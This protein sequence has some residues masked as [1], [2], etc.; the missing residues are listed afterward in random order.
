MNRYLLFGTALLFLISIGMNLYAQD[1]YPLTQ[2]SIR[3]EG[4]PEGEVK[5][6]FSFE[7]EIFP[8]T[9]RNYWIYVPQQYDSAKPACTM[10]VQDGIS[11]AND[12]KLQIA[13]DNLIHK[14]EIPITIGIFVA[15]GGVPSQKLDAFQRF[16]RSFEY[17]SLGDRYARFLIEELIPKV[18]E[19]Y[20][21]SDD[22]NDRLLAG[23]SSGGI[24]A[25]N[26]AWERPD[27]FRRVISTIGTF[28]GLRGGHEFPTLVR[29]MEPKPLRVYLQDGSSDLDI[30]AGSWWVANQDMLSSLQWAGYDVNH[31]W[32]KGGHN[33]RHGAAIM[34]DALRWIWRDYPAPVR[35]VEGK[36]RRTDILIPNEKWKLVHNAIGTIT[37]IISN[38][39][40]DVIYSVQNK[41]YVLNSNHQAKLYIEIDSE[42]NQIA[43]GKDGSL[44]ASIPS[45]KQIV[46]LTQDGKAKRVASDVVCDDFIVTEKGIYFV[47][48]SAGQC[49]FINTESKQTTISDLVTKPS[50]LSLNSE[51]AFLNVGDAASNFG[52]TYLIEL[53][54]TLAHGQQYMHYHVPYGKTTTEVSGM[55]TDT[56]NRLYSATNM[57]VQVMDQLGRVHIILENPKKYEELS[58]LT[59]GG[60]GFHSLFVT[61]GNKIYQRTIKATGTFAWDDPVKPPRPRL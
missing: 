58:G 39:Y 29:K 38:P 53:D 2:D 57:G 34:P 3:Q 41:I 37:Y 47:N 1:E 24:C 26:A 52:F 13:L 49:G 6:P 31:Q 40:G 36:G 42:I 22:P 51:H 56:E 32:G 4:V 43:L 15:W 54:G 27:A 10:I 46:T 14:K 55:A 59:F 33:G 16:N 28:V 20:N 30:Y 60:D 18:E 35:N 11:R 5:G 25:F 19:S 50:A 7:S 44:Y 45:K 48:G 17:D 9:V 23:A 12:W 8:G 61:S 21:L